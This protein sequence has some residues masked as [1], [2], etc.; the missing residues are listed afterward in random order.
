MVAHVI[1]DDGEKFESYI[2]CSMAMSP[3]FSISK[4]CV[5]FTERYWTKKS[6]DE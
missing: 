4:Y 2:F 5:D 6:V 3:L 1:W